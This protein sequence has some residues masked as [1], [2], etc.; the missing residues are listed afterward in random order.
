MLAAL[1]GY[2]PAITHGGQILKCGMYLL[3]SI[4]DACICLSL[5]FHGQ[6]AGYGMGVG[7]HEV[8]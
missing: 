1:Q 3:Y 6:I 7:D 8:A 5:P 4:A 2:S